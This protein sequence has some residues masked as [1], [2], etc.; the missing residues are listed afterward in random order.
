MEHSRR[1][2]SGGGGP[3]AS[4]ST[5]PTRSSRTRSRGFASD[6]PDRADH[7]DG[8]Q[9]V[10]PLH[11]RDARSGGL[12]VGSTT[13]GAPGRSRA[14]SDDCR[15]V[16]L[17]SATE[18]ID[19]TQFPDPRQARCSSAGTWSP[20]PPDILVTNYSMLNAMLMRDSRSRCS[21]RPATGSQSSDRPRL[22]PRRRRA[23][24]LPGHAGLRGGDDR[25]QPAAPP[26]AGA[27]LAAAALHRHQ[28]L[29][30]PWTSPGST[31]SSSSSV[32]TARRSSSPR[33]ASA[34]SRR[35]CRSRGCG[36][37]CLGARRCRRSSLR[38]DGRP[39]SAIAA[40]ARRARRRP[41][42]ATTL[43]RCRPPVRRADPMARRWTRSLEAL[44]DVPSAERRCRCARTCSSARLRGLWACSTRTC[45]RR[46]A[47]PRHRPLFGSRAPRA[48][49]VVAC[50]SSSTA[51]SAATSASAATSPDMSA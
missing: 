50:S 15:R 41:S 51:S 6:P 37:R 44:A 16:R 18:A 34:R 17:V 4:S 29:A 38:D 27:G 21:T 19:L 39:A 35:S 9:L 22:H 43:A 20:T 46:T 1:R 24:P 48:H 8:R 28:R 49:A 32:S 47:K 10:R 26:R 2:A 30:R 31:T 25:A 13:S 14:R 5:R 45:T 7:G 36:P 12:P 3:R 23:A 40:A 11:G 33:P 42:G